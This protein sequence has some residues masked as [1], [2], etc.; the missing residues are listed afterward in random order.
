MLT[1]ENSHMTAT[2]ASSIGDVVIV[3][4]RNRTVHN[5]DLQDA[6]YHLNCLSNEFS[7][8]ASLV[9]LLRPLAGPRSH[10]HGSLPGLDTESDGIIPADFEITSGRNASP[11]IF[12]FA[13]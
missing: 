9:C 7:T 4:N 2:Q 1:N 10:A 8:C 13:I 11:V 3:G 6:A 12:D 5:F